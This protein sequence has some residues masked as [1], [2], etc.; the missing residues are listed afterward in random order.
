M[1][2]M[3]ESRIVFHCG[4]PKTG[5]TIESF[6]AAKQGLLKGTLAYPGENSPAGNADWMVPLI[7]RNNL[8]RIKAIAMEAQKGS[9]AVL[10]SSKNLYPAIRIAP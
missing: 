10:F 3:T 7:M 1:T 6:F 5:T 4:L 8:P 9:P 2:S